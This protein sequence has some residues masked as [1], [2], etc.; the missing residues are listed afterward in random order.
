VCLK[1]VYTESSRAQ[2]PQ[3][4]EKHTK[5]VKGCLAGVSDNHG[6][7][8]V[9]KLY[10]TPNM[11]VHDVLAFAVLE[12]TMSGLPQHQRILPKWQSH[13]EGRKITNGKSRNCK[14]GKSACRKVKTTAGLEPGS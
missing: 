3:K 14:Q 8:A 7:P 1:V 5:H 4:V 6:G 13:L 11:P 10:R 9:Q 2:K 12:Q